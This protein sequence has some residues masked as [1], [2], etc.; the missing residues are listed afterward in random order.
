[1]P[2]SPVTRFLLLKKE[3]QPMSPREPAGVESPELRVD[4]LESAGGES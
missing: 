1:M 4:E 3:K 2:P